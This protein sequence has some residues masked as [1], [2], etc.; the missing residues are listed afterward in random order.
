MQS[1]S[2]GQYNIIKYYS[3]NITLELADVVQNIVIVM[4]RHGNF[5]AR[6]KFIKFL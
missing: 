5:F 2:L 1:Q 4:T 6:L 3:T